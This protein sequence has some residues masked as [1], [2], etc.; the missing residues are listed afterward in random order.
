MVFSKW[1]TGLISK[2][3]WVPGFFC[4]R[5]CTSVHQGFEFLPWGRMSKGQW[6]TYPWGEFFSPQ[7]GLPCRGIPRNLRSPN[8]WAP[9]IAWTPRTTIS[10][11]SRHGTCHES[12][13][14]TKNSIEFLRFDWEK[15]RASNKYWRLRLSESC[16]TVPFPHFLLNSSHFHLSSIIFFPELDDGQKTGKPYTCDEKPWSMNDHAI[17]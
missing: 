13:R 16:R 14:G 7:V 6:I 1:I 2:C 9:R 3:N 5:Y 4:D 11:S 17:L 15:N 12:R 8:S 10:P